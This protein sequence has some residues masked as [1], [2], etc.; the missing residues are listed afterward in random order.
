MDLV[1]LLGTIAVYGILFILLCTLFA[2]VLLFVFWR[3]NRTF[4][5]NL[6]LLLISAFSSPLKA[7]AKIFKINEAVIDKMIVKLMNKV[8]LNTFKKSGYS[9]R[10]LFL[11]QCLRNSDCSAK[12]GADGIAC[13]KCA[14]ECNVKE[15]KIEA[16]KLGYRVFIVPGGGFIRRIAAK[17]KPKAVVGVACLPEVMMG[18]ESMNKARL[19]SQG[20]VLLRSGCLNTVADMSELKTVLALKE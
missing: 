15:A 7:L 19:P 11:P 6:T 17:H 13:V 14:R 16:E 10:A 12:L 8:F 2:G 1:Y 3:W 4:F 18:M 5:P 9:D 20:V